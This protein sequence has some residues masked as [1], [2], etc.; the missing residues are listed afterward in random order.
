MTS[1][2]T[3]QE[4]EDKS[5]LGVAVEPRVGFGR[6]YQEFYCSYVESEMSEIFSWRH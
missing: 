5:E 1:D 2:T 3:Y 6:R 4:L